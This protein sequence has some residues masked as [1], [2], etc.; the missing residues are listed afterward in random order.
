MRHAAIAR[1][2]FLCSAGIVAPNRSRYSPP[3][4]RTTSATV[5]IG[6]GPIKLLDPGDRLLLAHRGQMEVDHRGLQRAVAEVL[7][8]QPQVDAGFEQVGGVAVPQ[9]VDRD[10]LA[11]TPAPGPPGAWPPGR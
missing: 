8:D 11:G 2:T 6:Q 3:Y 9:R 5:G 7:L 1:S 10:R 4:R